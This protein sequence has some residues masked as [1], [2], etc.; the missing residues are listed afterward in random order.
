[1]VYD[2]QWNVPN[3]DPFTGTQRMDEITGKALVSDLRI[4]RFIRD[5][6][7]ELLEDD[8]FYKYDEISIKKFMTEY[9]KSKMSGAAAV[10]NKYSTEKNLNTDTKNKSKDDFVSAKEVMLKFID[11]KLFGGV[12]SEEGNSVSLTGA[13][14]FKNLNESLN[15]VSL[16]TMQNTTIF[17]SSTDNSQGSIGTTLLVPYSIFAIEGWLDEETAKLN[18]LVDTDIE[19]MM[20][21]LWLGIKDK[22]TKSKTQQSPILMLEINYKGYDYKYNENKKIYKTIKNLKS[23]ISLD[24]DISD[25]DIR[26]RGDFK[27]NIDSLIE[28]CNSEDIEYVNFYSEDKVIKESLLQNSKFK[29]KDIN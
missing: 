28:S 13:V 15:K 5:K 20:S 7:I 3:G 29:F 23:L 10:F 1:M 11:V 26:S 4:K 17:P 14:Q 9:K 6:F 21:C 24:T 8:I 2:N 22:N 12:L 18:G 27:M 16:Y 19:K 25:E